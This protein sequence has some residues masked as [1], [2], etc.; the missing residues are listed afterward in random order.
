MMALKAGAHHVIAVERWLYLGLAAR[1]A[2]LANGFT[3]D[4]FQVRFLRLRFL[5]IWQ[6]LF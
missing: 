4:K 3:E 6:V 1:E 2:L 5:L